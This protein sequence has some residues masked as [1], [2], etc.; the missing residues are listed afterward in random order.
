MVKIDLPVINQ[1]PIDKLVGRRVLVRS[2]LDVPLKDGVVVDDFRLKKSLATIDFLRAAGARVI[3]I[4]HL[5]REGKSLAPVA[6][7]YAELFPTKLVGSIEEVRLALDQT[8]NNEVLML[9]NLRIFGGEEKDDPVFVSSLATL[10]DYYV[11]NA[12]ASSHRAHASIVGLPEHLPSYAG[13]LFAEE[14]ANLSRV[15]E[16][17]PPLIV[18]LGGAKFETKLSLLSKLIDSAEKIFVYGALAHAFFKEKGYE[19]GG[20]FVD[21]DT[22]PARAFIDHPKIVLPV[23]VRVKN[24]DK[25]F[26]K[27]PDKLTTEDNILD[28]GLLSLEH[29]LPAIT[30]AGFVLWNGPLGFFE[31]GFRGSTEA[32]AKLIIGSN[33]ISVV[34]GGDTISAIRSLDLLSQ[35]DFVS[36][37][38][39]AMLE[40]LTQGTLPGIEALEKSSKQV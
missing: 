16:P 37:G 19:L 40:F 7:W 32:T 3:L 23:D 39:G 31:L 20:S 26:I 27:T 25:I 15:F 14:V 24:G 21:K 36:T 6:K 33:A 1:L 35:F 29:L 9:E 17:A 4:G 28:V 12:F 13:L 8:P 5:G 34:G 18:I 30:S 10:A 11:N 38:G 2:D 22:S